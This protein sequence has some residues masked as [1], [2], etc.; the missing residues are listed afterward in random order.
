MAKRKRIMK[1]FAISEI[2]AV[3]RP[4]QAGAVAVFIKRHEQES[5][6]ELRK[7]TRDEPISFPTLEAAMDHLLKSHGMS[8]SSA[9]STAAREHPDLLA[10]YQREGEDRIAK[11]ADAGKPQPVSKA[12]MEFDDRVEQIAK[13]R[14]LPRH[15]AMKKAR[16][17]YPD[18]FAA[19]YGHEA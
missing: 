16:E 6:M 8:R 17:R 15:Q 4:A 11:A 19:A 5:K 18:E 13:G 2:S 9:M 3:D 1:D 7:V 12:V 10:K 14:G